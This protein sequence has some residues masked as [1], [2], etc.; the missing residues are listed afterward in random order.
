M[1]NKLNQFFLKKSNSIT[2]YIFWF[3]FLVIMVYYSLYSKDIPI[4]MGYLFWLLLGIRLGFLYAIKFISTNN[5]A[6][7]LIIPARLSLRPVLLSEFPDAEFREILQ[8]KYLITIRVLRD[9]FNYTGEALEHLSWS[10]FSSPFY[11]ESVY[12]P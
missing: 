7:Q 1:K 6:D 2:L 5:N 3:Y 10:N 9:T 8:I 11:N 4:I 12:Q